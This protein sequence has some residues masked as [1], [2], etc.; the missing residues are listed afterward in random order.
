[1]HKYGEIKNVIPKD[2][3][4]Q[5]RTRTLD[6]I[7]ALRIAYFPDLDTDEVMAR[8]MHSK[9]SRFSRAVAYRLFDKTT[10]DTLLPHLKNAARSFWGEK[11]F[12]FYP[13]FYVRYSPASLGG[14]HFLDSQPHYDRSFQCF[15][16][17]FW[18]PLEQS[19]ESTGGI[20][21]FTDEDLVSAFV[22]DSGKNSYDFLSYKD[23]SE[24]LDPLLRDKS[25]TFTL[26]EGDVVTFDSDLLHGA[27]RPISK[28]RFSFD[29][30][31][32]CLDD[33]EP[34]SCAPDLINTFNA[35]VD[36]SNAMNLMSLGDP[37]GA[38]AVVSNLDFDTLPQ[39]MKKTLS[40]LKATSDLPSP[41][42]LFDAS[43]WYTEYAWFKRYQAAIS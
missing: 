30:R 29:V 33:Q 6:I 31:L 39:V 13:V 15:A 25:I 11:T 35:H 42:D 21:L 24:K 19:N 9:P 34:G 3:I 27:T 23:N 17:S 1:M 41:N 20:C 10:I 43:P 32:I 7:E 12:T 36:V 16:Y 14:N 40:D 8:Y 22:Q 2:V 18:I 26:D 38:N 5:L 28:A 37:L 4:F